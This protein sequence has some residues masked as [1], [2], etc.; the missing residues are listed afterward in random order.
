MKKYT[1]P[2]L[3]K[4]YLLVSEVVLTAVFM[5]LNYFLWSRAS[6][7]NSMAKVMQL[8][9]TYLARPYFYLALGMII[10]VIVP[11]KPGIYKYKKV[12]GAVGGLLELALFLIMLCPLLGLSD[13]S[14]FIYSMANVLLRYGIIFMIPA[15]LMGIELFDDKPKQQE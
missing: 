15:L 2:T 1:Q 7:Q 12:L 9:T 4:L 3:I 13:S 6:D 10:G 14:G 5:L 11:L 8:I